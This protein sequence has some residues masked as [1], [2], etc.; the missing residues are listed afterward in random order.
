LK[1]RIPLSN[2]CTPDKARNIKLEFYVEW[3]PNLKASAPEEKE[4]ALLER[5]GPLS[6]LN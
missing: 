5:G 4:S 1:E 2:P 3:S 6:S